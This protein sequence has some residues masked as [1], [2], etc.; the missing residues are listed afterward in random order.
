MRNSIRASIYV[1]QAFLPV[2]LSQT[3]RTH[4][5]ECLC[6]GRNFSIFISEIMV[7]GRK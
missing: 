5:Q 1:A 4:R 3:W 6:H 7:E 2:R